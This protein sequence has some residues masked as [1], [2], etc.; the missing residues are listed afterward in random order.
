MLSASLVALRIHLLLKLIVLVV[1]NR[2]F[3]RFSFGSEFSRDV[4]RVCSLGF[5]ELWYLTHA[6]FGLGTHCL[7]WLTC[8]WLEYFWTLDSVLSVA[9]L[10]SSSSHPRGNIG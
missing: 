1:R 5:T 10:T 9:N 7:A 3:S 4:A 6:R 8:A 2:S